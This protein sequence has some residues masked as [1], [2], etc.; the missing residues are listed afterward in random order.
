MLLLFQIATDDAMLW[1]WGD[2]GACY[3]WIQPQDLEARD[4]SKVEIWLECH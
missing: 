4:F 1:V 2:A 3:F